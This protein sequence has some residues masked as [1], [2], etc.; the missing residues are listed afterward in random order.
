MNSQ[1]H[2]HVSVKKLF[3][4]PTPVL[5][6]WKRAIDLTCCLIALPL[7]AFLAVTMAILLRLTSRGPILFK[8]E[9]IGYK[10]S[11]FLC[12][13]FRTMVVGAE[14]RVTKRIWPTFSAPGRPWSN[15]TPK[16]TTG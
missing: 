3:T 7:M 2:Q 13:K 11:R 10:G 4:S 5:P 14:T 15:S 6:Y 8:Q 12:Y 16:A 9:R 1:D